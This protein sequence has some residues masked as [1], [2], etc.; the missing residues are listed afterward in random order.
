MTDNTG[1][2]ISSLNPYFN[3]NT[4]IYWMCNNAEAKADFMGLAHYR[5]YFV[6]REL[7]C[8][9]DGEPVASS[10]DFVE[11][12]G[13]S[14]DMIVAQPIAF[15]NEK[16][17]T[18]FTVEQ[19]Y[20][21]CHI[22]FDLFTAREA[23]AKIASEYLPAFDFV[24]RNGQLI[25]YNMFVGKRLVVEQYA[26]WIFP[27]LFQLNEWIPYQTYVDPYQQR[28]ISFLSERLFT[29]WVLHN[30]S[31]VKFGYRHVMFNSSL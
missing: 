8:I 21:G 31:R 3:E 16:T 18:L 6:A 7:C 29:V 9:V 26:N 5:R 1:H 28:A 10:N 30:R 11:L 24:M 23:L 15:V 17:D 12:F 20:A 19:S 22:S 25:A 14:V 4:A 13:G 27:I 2:N